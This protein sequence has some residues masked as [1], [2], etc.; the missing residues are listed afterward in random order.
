M[1]VAFPRTPIAATPTLPPPHIDPH[2]PRGQIPQ[3]G[4]EGPGDTVAVL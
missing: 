3:F 1:A 4:W 2:G